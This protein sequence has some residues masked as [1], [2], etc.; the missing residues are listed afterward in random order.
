LKRGISVLKNPDCTSGNRTKNCINLVTARNKSVWC[1][2]IV[3]KVTVNKKWTS[4]WIKIGNVAIFRSLHEECCVVTPSE[5]K[6]SWEVVR[7]ESLYRSPSTICV[8]KPGCISFICVDVESSL[9]RLFD[10]TDC[11]II[12]WC[13]RTDNFCVITQCDGNVRAKI[14]HLLFLRK[15]ICKLIYRFSR[16]TFYNGG[17]IPTLNSHPWGKKVGIFRHLEI[18]TLTWAK[19]SFFSIVIC[20]STQSLRLSKCEINRTVLK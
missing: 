19:P 18:Q 6:R 5:R 1:I 13:R 11:Y 14:C 16:Y 9:S 10:G 17:K 3:R 12:G 8:L 7:R 20:M 4:S 2:S 15:C